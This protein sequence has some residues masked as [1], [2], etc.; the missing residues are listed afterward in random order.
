M[1]PSVNVELGA[2]GSIQSAERTSDFDDVIDG[3]I[4][5]HGGRVPDKPRGVLLMKMEK[6]RILKGG[7]KQNGDL[8]VQG[9]HH[10]LGLIHERD[11]EFVFSPFPDRGLERIT[12]PSQQAIIRRLRSEKQG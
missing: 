1:K 7:T 11:G 8:V 4:G 12:A 3:I 9:D 10:R 6:I 5:K 2:D